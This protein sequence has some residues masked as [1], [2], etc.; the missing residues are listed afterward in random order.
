VDRLPR[1]RPRIGAH[2]GIRRAGSVHREAQRRPQATADKTLQQIVQSVSDRGIRVRSLLAVGEI[3][4]TILRA[5]TDEGVDLIVMST[6][7][8]TG[9]HRLIL[10]SVA[11][12]VV[13]HAECPVMKVHPEEPRA[14]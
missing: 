5:A 1:R 12:K 13:R 8:R 4:R 6:H 10:G 11:E 14:D 7:G 9:W 2:R 3:V